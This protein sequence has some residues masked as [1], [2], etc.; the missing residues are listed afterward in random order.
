MIGT[1]LPFCVQDIMYG[2]VDIKDI[3][4]IFAGTQFQS[5]DQACRHFTRSYWRENPRE[6]IQI[7]HKLWKKGL[8]YQ[9]KLKNP[10]LSLSVGKIWYKDSSEFIHAYPGEGSKN[11][12]R[13]LLNMLEFTTMI[14]TLRANQ[15]NSLKTEEANYAETC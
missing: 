3:K 4:V 14:D 13:I 10:E 5:A 9:Y 8:I 15:E 6:A 11:V 2:R 7:C 12:P 1:S